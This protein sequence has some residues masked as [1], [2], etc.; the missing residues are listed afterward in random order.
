MQH[1]ILP[2]LGQSV[3]EA[4]IVEWFKNEGDTVEKG[5]R[6]FSVQTDKAE[7]EVEAEAAGVLRKI[8]VQPDVFIP[9][10]TVVGLIGTADEPL[11]DLKDG[12]ETPPADAPSAADEDH[13]APKA[14]KTTPTATPATSSAAVKGVSPRARK[15][16]EG[17]GVETA[18]IQGSGPGGRVIEQDVQAAAKTGAPL[19]ATPTARRIAANEGVNLDAVAGTGAQGK[20]TKDDVLQA[21]RAETPTVGKDERVPLSPMRRIIAER[22]VTSKFSAPH[23]YITVEVDMSAAAAL[24]SR[25]PIRPSFN[26]L[27]MVAAA[28]ALRAFPSVN[29]RWAGDAVELLQGVHIGLAVALPDGLVVP[30]VRNVQDLSLDGVA[31][32]SRALV[33]KAR[34][35]KLRPDDYAGS[36]FT[37]SNLGA[38]GVD[39]F[40]AIINQP[41]AAILAAGQIKD[42]PVVIDG[43]IHVRPIMKL[44]LSSD[45][46]IVD[47]A[48]AAQFMGRMKAILEDGE[49]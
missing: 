26:D 21:A 13:A 10:L 39:Q 45:H 27:L 20:I 47:G 7:I 36:T 9:V 34:N 40:T 31:N 1:V 19:K 24:R 48:V 49:F 25:L 2:Q 42:R 30:V 33:E 6:L 22:M 15:T 28:R 23:Y 41:N 38:F 3:E 16:A 44:T 43:G 14:E 4:S 12:G 29:A 11:P 5:E 17:L 37:I 8:L 18:A 32:Q 46:R 35:G